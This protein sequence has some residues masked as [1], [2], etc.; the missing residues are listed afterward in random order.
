MYK[1]ILCWLGFHNWLYNSEWVDI[2]TCRECRRCRKR[3][4]AVG[5]KLSFN[6]IYWI[7]GW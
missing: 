4:Q 3:Q 1:R 2:G 7:E 6:G 5:D